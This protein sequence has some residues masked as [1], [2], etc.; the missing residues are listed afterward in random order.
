MK[1]DLTGLGEAAA[2]RL[3]FEEVDLRGTRGGSMEVVRDTGGAQYAVEKGSMNLRLESVSLSACLT[4]V[5]GIQHTNDD[6]HSVGH[7]LDQT[8]SSLPI[9]PAKSGRDGL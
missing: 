2:P 5:R 1:K 6:L 7:H 4:R 9:L 3:M 8:V